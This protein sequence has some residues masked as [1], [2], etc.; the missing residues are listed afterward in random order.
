MNKTFCI[1]I[2]LLVG[3]LTYAQ[4]NLLPIQ[5]QGKWGLID[6]TGQVVLPIKYGSIEVKESAFLIKSAQLDSIGLFSKNEVINWYS[7]SAQVYVWSD[8]IFLY[9]N[10]KTILYQ[11]GQETNYDLESFESIHPLNGS[12]AL[13]Q[14]NKK[15]GLI[16]SALQVVFPIQYDSIIAYK[17]CYLTRQEN[18]QTNANF[19]SPP[20]CLKG[21]CPASEQVD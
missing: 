15:Y 5:L 18:E 14:K 13:I 21:F 17:K 8:R 16:D 9:D 19:N 3:L 12:L 20:K 10:G 4:T 7:S 2:F 6:S 1:I 11:D